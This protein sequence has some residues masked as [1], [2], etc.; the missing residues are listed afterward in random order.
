MDSRIDFASFCNSNHHDIGSI[1]AV[2]ESILLI[3][4]F[5]RDLGQTHHVWYITQT[6]DPVTMTTTPKVHVDD[7]LGVKYKG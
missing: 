2:T 3:F 5:C 1:S 4:D 6:D 7:S